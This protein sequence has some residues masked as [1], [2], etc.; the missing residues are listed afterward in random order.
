MLRSAPRFVAAVLFVFATGTGA[1]DLSKTAIYAENSAYIKREA[2][3]SGNV[4]VD[5]V[6][7][8]PTLSPPYE[9]G[10]ARSADLLGG[11]DIFADSI[12]M[13]LY[14]VIEG[15]IF[16]NGLTIHSTASHTGSQQSL[17]LPVIPNLPMFQE[18]TPGTLD[19][20]VDSGGYR[21]LWPGRYGK[22]N[23]V[24]GI[25]SLEPGNYTFESV[26]IQTNAYLKFPGPTNVRI[27]E[28]LKLADGAAL[29]NDSGTP[30]VKIYVAGSNGTDGGFSSLPATVEVGSGYAV[31][32]ASVYAPYGTITTSSS[33][34]G[35]LFAR[36]VHTGTVVGESGFSELDNRPLADARGL[37]SRVGETV[38]FELTGSG[39]TGAQLQFEIVTQPANGTLTFIQT[40]DNYRAEY[41]YEPDAGYVGFDNFEF[42]VAVGGVQSTV[43]EVSNRV[44]PSEDIQLKETVA[45]ATNSIEFGREV[46]VKSG[47]VIVNAPAAGDT[48]QPGYEAFFG[49]GVFLPQ[50][51]VVKADRNLFGEYLH[52]DV[53]ISGTK[54]LG[55]GLFGGRPKL[56][57]TLVNRYDEPVFSNLPVFET[58]LPGTQDVSVPASGNQTIVQGDFGDITVG[59][60]GILEFGPGLYNIKS[61]SIGVD[62]YVKVD[63]STRLRIDE[64][65]FIDDG[66]QLI[67]T[68]GNSPA[69][70]VLYVNGQNGVG[71]GIHET[72]AAVQLQP[73]ASIEAN[74]YAPNGTIRLEQAAQAV[75]ALIA[76]DIFV[77]KWSSLTLSNG[78]SDPTGGA[79][80]FA[81]SQF[82]NLTEDSSAPVTLTGT[83]GQG[84]LSFTVLSEPM[85]GSLTGSPPN[86]TYQPD[87][88]FFGQDHF[89]F[90][91]SDGSQTS[92]PASVTFKVSGVNDPPVAFDATYTT[93]VDVPVVLEDT[94]T[95]VDG[96][97]LTVTIVSAPANGT[98]SEVSGQRIY[99][100]NAGFVGTDSFTY[101]VS[102]GS[103]TSNVAT[104]T[105]EVGS[106]SS[107]PVATDQTIN[108]DE[109]TNAA[110]AL[111][112]TDPEGDP[113]TFEILTAPGSGVLSGTAPNLTY[114]PN[115]DF[116]GSDSFTYRAN[117]GTSNSN[118]ATVTLDVAP[119]NDSPEANSDVVTLAEDNTANITVIANDI[120]GDTLTY[121]V[122]T[123]PLNGVLS[124]SGPQFTYTPNPNFNG[125]DSFAYVANDG[126][127]N[128]NEATV[129]LSISAVND[130]PIASGASAV[131]EED[132][133]VV[134]SVSASDV[135]SASLS[136]VVS[137]PPSH[138]VVSGNGPDFIYTPNPG[139]SGSDSFSFVAN[140][141]LSDSVPALVSI[142][143]NAVN[144]PPIA[145]DIAQ[146]LNEDESVPVVLSASDEDGDALTF[147]LTSQPEHGELTGTSPNL[148]YTPDPDF[149]GVDSFTY[150]AFD[151]IVSSMGATVT[152][153]VTAVNDLPL[154]QDDLINLAEDTTAM[155]RL[156]AS[157]ADGD[158]LTFA[159]V[160]AP[161][162]GTLVG[163]GSDYDYTPSAGFSGTDSLTFVAN[164]G[165][166]DS[167][168]ATITLVVEPIND[169]P[170][171]EDLSV[172]TNEDVAVALTLAGTDP[173]GDVISFAVTQA[174][175]RGTLSGTPPNL[176]YLPNADENGEDTFRFTVSDGIAESDPATVTVQ[177]SAQND[178][179]VA[180]P[181][182]LVVTEASLALTLTGSDVDG[183]PLTYQVV[184][185]PAGG[186]LTGTA[187]NLTYTRNSGFSGPDSFT[188]QV[189]D[190]QA[191]SAAAVVNLDVQVNN[192]APE[193]ISTPVL[194]AAE[195]AA[196][197]YDV[198]A[199]DADGDS[200]TYSLVIAPQGMS[201]DSATGLISWVPLS[202]TL[203]AVDVRVRASDPQGAFAEQDYVVTVPGSTI[204]RSY[205]GTDFWLTF[206][207]NDIDPGPPAVPALSIAAPGG[208]SGTIS[209]ASLAIDIPFTI[210]AGG[211]ERIELPISVVTRTNGTPDP[212]GVNVGADAPITVM[213]FN[214]R[215]ASTDA[216]QVYPTNV[217]ASDYTIPAF[218]SLQLGA[219]GIVATEDNTLV[220]VTPGP[221]VTQMVGNGTFNQAPFNIT[222]QQGDVWTN[223]PG[224]RARFVTGTTLRS[225]RPIGVFAG[226]ICANVPNEETISCDHLI[227]QVPG[228][229]QLATRFLSV[230]FATRFNGDLFRFVA[231][232]DDTVVRVNG[233]ETAY[234]D[235]LEFVDRVIDGV[236]EITSTA[237]IHA[238]QIA[239]G[240]AFDAVERG[241]TEPGNSDADPFMVLL[242]PTTAY[243]DE[244]IFTTA[245]T[246]R[247]NSHYVNV[248]IPDTAA[249]SL[250]LDGQPADISTLVPIEDT[251]YLGGAIEVSFGTHTMSA[252]EKF[253]ITIYGWGPAESYGTNG[254]A[255]LGDLPPVNRL[256]V[257]PLNQTQ[258]VG[259][260]ACFTITTKN[261]LDYAVPFARIDV[262]V[263]GARTIR[264]SIA[265]NDTGTA[266]YCYIGIDAGTETATFVSGPAI[267]SANVTWEA[268]PAGTQAAPII[269]SLP[270][271][272]LNE[273]THAYTIDAFDP[274]GDAIT[275]GLVSGPAGVTVDGASGTLSWTPTVPQDR[276]ST[277][278]AIS[279]SATDPFGN[280]G[281]QNYELLVNYAPVFSEITPEETESFAPTFTV[282]AI[283]GNV[284]TNQLAIIEAPPRATVTNSGPDNQWLLQ[285]GLN[286]TVGG[287]INLVREALE[288]FNP[289]CRAPLTDR[290]ALNVKSVWTSTEDLKLVQ[291][292]PLTDTD[293]NGAI[294]TAD[295]Q[296]I[297]GIGPDLTALDAATGT[298]L[299]R[300]SGAATIDVGAAIADIDGDNVPEVLVANDAATGERHLYAY[301]NLGDLLWESVTPVLP[302]NF[303][304][305]RTAIEVFDLNGDGAVEIVVG[306]SVLDGTGNLLW[307]FN[308]AVSSPVVEA[309]PWIADLE[310]DGQYEVLFGSEIRNA[311][312]S[313]RWSINTAVGGTNPVAQFVA[314]D[315]DQ[316]GS[317]DIIASVFDGLSHSLWVFEAG[318]SVKW[319]PV[320]MEDASLPVVADFDHD[321]RLEIYAPNDGLRLSETGEAL[322]QEEDAL[323]INTDFLRV[324]VGD[325][326]GDG[327][328]EVIRLRN[329]TTIEIVDVLSG[330]EWYSEGGFFDLDARYGGLAL[331][332]IDRDG[333]V[334]ILAGA[335]SNSSS[336]FTKAMEPR[337]TGWVSGP[338]STPSFGLVTTSNEVNIAIPARD[339]D[340]LLPDLWIGKLRADSVGAG[341]EITAKLTNRGPADV[342][343]AVT[344][345]FYRG[346]PD[347]PSAV[348]LGT[349]VVSG[350]RST[351][352]ATVMLGGL[353]RQQVS[354]DIAVQ[355]VTS[356]IECETRNNR[357]MTPVYE[358][359]V[360]DG[361]NRGDRRLFLPG[362]LENQLVASIA[363]ESPSVV[364]VGSTYVY[365]IDL[366][367][368]NIGDGLRVNVTG[369]NLPS[370]M[371]WNQEMGQIRWTPT[372]DDLGS[373]TFFIQA[374]DLT[375]RV[376]S[377]RV[378]LT[379]VAMNNAA[380]TITSQPEIVAA[381]DSPYS[382]DVEATDPDG[383]PLTFSL[384]TA[385]AGM[386]IDANSGV[387]S[388]TPTAADEGQPMVSVLVNDGLGGQ[389]VQDFAITVGATINSP[390]VINQLPSDQARVSVVYNDQI[391]ATDA[392]GDP[393]TFT[394]VSGLNVVSINPSTGAVFYSPSNSTVGFHTIEFTVSD[395]TYTVPGSWNITVAPSN[396]PLQ[397]AVEL[398]DTAVQPNTM[399]EVGVVATGAAGPYM[400]SLTMDGA[401]I[402]LDASGRAMVDSGAPGLRSFVGTAVDQRDT[403]NDQ[404]DLIVI[405]PSDVTPPLVALT[406]PVEGDVVTAPTPMIGDVLDDN[407]AIWRVFLQQGGTRPV[408]QEIA[409]GSNEGTGI[410]LGDFDPTMLMNGAYS[411]VLEATDLGGNM[412]SDSIAIEVDGNMKVGHFSI[413]L[414]DVS[415]DMVGIPLQVTRTY[416]TRQR[417]ENL[418][419]GYGWSVDYQNMRLTESRAPG[420]FWFI[421]E[422]GGS[423]GQTCA[424]SNGDNY[425]NIRLPDGET[426]R[427]RAVA[428][429]EC[430]SNLDFISDP[431]FFLGFEPLGDTTSELEQASFG[432]LRVLSG[433]L[434]DLGAP[435]EPVDPKFYRL[436]T[437]EGF[438]YEL[439]ESFGIRQVID[440]NGNTLTYTDSGIFHS[441]GKQIDFVRDVE[442]RI[443]EMVLPN[444]TSLRYEYDGN[445]D[446]V[447]MTDQ[448]N[449]V[450][451]YTYLPGHYLENL[452]DLRGTRVS[453]NEY[454]ADGRLVAV[455]DATNRRIELTHD[456]A[457]RSESVRDRLG[458]T[459]VYQ[460]DERGNVLFE[461]NALNETIG[462]TYDEF[463]NQLTETDP[464]GNTTTWTYDNRGNQLTETNAEGE[465]TTYTY[466]TRGQVLTQ[467]DDLGNVVVTNVYDLNGNIGRSTDALGNETNFVVGNG[468]RSLGLLFSITD[469]EGGVTSYTYDNSGNRLSETDQDGNVMEWSYD[470]NNNVLSETRRRV[471]N[472]GQVE[473]SVTSYEYDDKDRRIFSTDSFGNF[474]E[475]VYDDNG[476]VTAEFDE[477]R[478]FAGYTF[479]S[480]GNMVSQRFASPAD[481]ISRTYDNENRLIREFD[482]NNNRTD[483]TYDEAGRLL[484]T[485]YDDE[486]SGLA[487]N[488]R[489]T[490]EYD[491]AGRLTASIDERGNRTEYEYDGAGRRTL[492]RNALNQVTTFEYDDRGLRVAMTDANSRT[493][494]YVYD[495]AERLVETIFPDDTPG[496]DTDN[497]RMLMAYDGLGRKISETD[498]L[499]RITQFEYDG[500]GNLTAVIDA[501]NQHTEYGYDGMGNKISQTDALGRVT[502][503]EYDRLGRVV[504]RTLPLGQAE[505]FTY[506]D[507]GNRIT[508]V[509][510]NGAVTN[511]TYN[512]DNRVETET[513]EDF[514]TRSWTYRSDGSVDTV[515]DSRGVTEY[516]YDERDR[517]TRITY[518]DGAVVEY[519]YDEASNRVALITANQSVVYTY[520]VLNRLDTVTDDTGTTGYTYDSVGLRS[521]MTYPN[522]TQTV[523]TYDERN[524]L[525]GIDHVGPGA[526]NLLGL[527][528]VL[529]DNGTR[530]QILEDSGR[531]VTY[532]YDELNRLTQEAV[533]DPNVTDRTTSWVYDSV[534]NRLSQDDA[535]VVTTYV[536]NDNDQLLTETSGSD[537]NTYIYDANGNT[538]QK[539]VNGVTEVTYQW[540]FEDRLVGATNASNVSYTYD[541]NG[542]RQSQTV[543][544]VTTRFLVDPNRD[545]AQVIEERDGAGGVGVVYT[546]GDDLISQQRIADGK[547]G[548]Y[549]YDGLGSTR[550]VTA[551][552]GIEVN[553]YVYE[554]F[555]TEESSN[556][557]QVNSFRYTG[558]HFDQDL[559]G[560]YL[561]ARYLSPS[562]GRFYSS[563]KFVG[564]PQLPAT[565]H[566]YSYANN[567]PV[568]FVDPSGYFGL[569]TLSTNV[570]LGTGLRFGASRFVR[571]TFKKRNLNVFVVQSFRP[572]WHTFIYVERFPRPEGIRYDVGLLNTNKATVNSRPFSVFDGVVRARPAIRSSIRGIKKRVARLSF[573]QWL[574]WHSTVVGSSDSCSIQY[575]LLV[576]NCTT[577][578]AAAAAKAILIS[579]AIRA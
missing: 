4:V 327:L 188:F 464:L 525:T 501:L 149:N 20:T 474:T 104:I 569:A 284:D 383:D 49:R 230:P 30:N 180:D 506:D 250:V 565:L 11:F 358:L 388:W 304:E 318:G 546:H 349:Q 196:Y 64:S 29:T 368:P 491:A 276:V 351:Q 89:L 121:Q 71:G 510:F 110:V 539:R 547:T 178:T 436:T 162:N 116:N 219:F 554:A 235:A 119:V 361:P 111:A 126:N 286:N 177:I 428:D 431:F 253:G 206:L 452:D 338:V 437:Q 249:A 425:V 86:L 446:L 238:A 193:I 205:L 106:A 450:A 414:E 418:D 514:S 23:V 56:G 227:E 545:Y 372:I 88:D 553:E 103:A 27:S 141:G 147:A 61:L 476:R 210:P 280:Q 137:T 479:D 497:D 424:K 158:L 377:E 438:I 433:D 412:A 379:V 93:D 109:D 182:S 10:I 53:D 398:A 577:W 469:A 142:V 7:S 337:G 350:L 65:L 435:D 340:A 41:R 527:T 268:L 357:V 26:D 123:Q 186:T 52:S 258:T 335:D 360:F 376:A 493:T 118:A 560:Y 518:P 209:V 91:A 143:V 308:T 445:G 434:V 62:A 448:I 136:F 198:D 50:S 511:W 68:Y 507:V 403:V 328:Y 262:R 295:D 275:Y 563:D 459:T 31:F 302:G 173:D 343:S 381:F 82:I 576:R 485:I 241:A 171:A 410:S 130:I 575:N 124:G 246:D 176:T 389:G 399:V 373:Y 303:D 263:S 46:F 517:L 495:A 197:A 94:A 522:G 148:T 449:S 520:D 192:S 454:D 382:Y 55:A 387:I 458:N 191:D 561:R 174:P 393:L 140:D 67:P 392:D 508:R 480:K 322:A 167:N 380:P 405:D 364:A 113:L 573:V 277:L 462:R 42:R 161:A 5:S 307:Q 294:N 3:I 190:G 151:G 146:T 331:A 168:L 12:D 183:D 523:Y 24:D 502:R 344:V 540:D 475:T 233:V 83:G 184:V 515:T 70:I 524:R 467:T 415:I 285:S 314:S 28:K 470:Q 347:S 201:I 472:N 199:S 416:D 367:D 212:V 9:L 334:E 432:P 133:S 461:T 498:E 363:S 345:E 456:I 400:L 16:T 165:A 378:D 455:I 95:D 579:L 117:D 57:G 401:S 494:R 97:S 245:G 128:S 274:N 260:N 355:L 251:G 312:G 98:V 38:T 423:F 54:I 293:G 336:I 102:D 181:Q 395:G 550:L 354:G 39:P 290:S 492:V 316:D 478:N 482:R 526:T 323:G 504:S 221:G 157:D 281:V 578:T 394:K 114:V 21:V 441:A 562:L 75:G 125:A 59:D 505:Y 48:L 369:N 215:T 556:E 1:D 500:R 529:N 279:V 138:G 45:L 564:H 74:V 169:P 444:G 69:S 490:N 409:S 353:T 232:T 163:G 33:T 330:L 194:D 135:E 234:L 243:L 195:G 231:T 356:E 34:T 503:W 555:G 63:G 442:G 362:L 552:N 300:V 156:T 531:Q 189:S 115:V 220:T 486:T 406:A 342:A 15:D 326:N 530:A 533:I 202:D 207:R 551:N 549:H 521:G 305:T 544:G 100:P 541:E 236:A 299:W 537:V 107:P 543:G 288:V 568:L 570:T 273:A 348:L 112:A 512:N 35:A 96:D 440:N 542:I 390:P 420:Q 391:V 352:S 218:H 239:T 73:T 6:S 439:D 60:N 72:P 310:G 463:D 332:D 325:F 270:P 366:V 339:V 534:G 297:I 242:P 211:L 266:N 289:Y 58:G 309:L 359:E 155:V 185:S 36:D 25:L 160:D 99:T 429:P 43:A 272:E 108:L 44:L 489:T 443:S 37:F 558:E 427:F 225:S 548:F 374:R 311:D 214:E 92:N 80:P 557:S 132:S 317:T 292:A 384:G 22:L 164:D 321:G 85:F 287:E 296:A 254:N 451:E 252:A 466:D 535:G 257:T 402:P 76:R 77:D 484:E 170:T 413:T 264:Q 396:Q 516:D 538:Q 32:E 283:G 371:S 13:E 407:L 468:G 179:P 40:L 78:F 365:D 333:S 2:Y 346:D 105:I 131:V 370:D 224:S 19:I 499:G 66:G 223:T 477:N 172:S 483:M 567:D 313:L 200:L 397:V 228:D 144:D 411:L 408:V 571:N 217:L 237:P 519:Q 269:I 166:A 291:V 329:G 513:F 120:D 47:N 473:I 271:L 487:D 261:G 240:Q 496:D 51:Y 18:S 203:G 315:L 574:I 385:P 222:L 229:D 528:Y 87:P 447:S 248:I 187:P 17:T 386:T 319:G 226:A 488:P 481:S 81:D 566:K 572:N 422:Q 139:F 298:F 145:V 426:H 244:Y 278:H 150:Q 101:T 84:S 417:N 247:L 532:T 460:Y 213:A 453:T 404:R 324:V 375:G 256:E 306:P 265:T 282:R 90:V 79:G 465:T 14:S 267:E 301:S 175:L 536:Y 154:A 320:P 457:A 8:G 471:N 419:F 159:I 509:D 259:A 559:G 421:E 255:I 152:L 216:A 341:Y 430:K 153:T 129:S 127:V 134:V 122:I 204:N 208:A